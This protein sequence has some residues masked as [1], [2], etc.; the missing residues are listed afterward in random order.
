MNMVREIDHLIY[1]LVERLR[2][3]RALRIR[4]GMLQL[5]LA[6]LASFA[7]SA[8]WLD[9]RED[10][11]AGAFPPMFLIANGLFLILSLAAGSSVVM[12]AGPQVGN[13]HDGWKWAVAMASLLPLSA[14]IMATLHH[15]DDP[16]I[17]APE[18]DFNCVAYGT[19]FGLLMATALTRRLRRGAP[20]SP[21][22]ASLLVG[23]AAGAIGVCA[24]GIS[25]PLD[26]IFHIGIWHSVPVLI[27]GFFGRLIIPALIRW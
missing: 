6:A 19:G 2:P 13:R 15:H 23:I 3:V 7:L 20:V 25:C 4:S 27:S 21:E 22:R 16:P 8:L 12:M 11:L 9:I 24:Y 17:L 1:D 26:T 10:L 18:H 14:I 5:A